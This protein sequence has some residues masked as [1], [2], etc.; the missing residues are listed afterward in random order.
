MWQKGQSGNPRGR[1]LKPLLFTN[2]I[3][4]KL[5]KLNKFDPPD[6]QRR[7]KEAIADKLIELALDGDLPAIK[8]VLDRIQGKVAQP[9]EHSGEDGGPIRITWLNE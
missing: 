8:E 3:L 9:L 7:N 2:I 1:P 5:K 6:Q 4:K